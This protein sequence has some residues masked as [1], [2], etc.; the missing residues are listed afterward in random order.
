MC[1]SLPSQGELRLTNV[2]DGCEHTFLLRGVAEKPLAQDHIVL[3]AQAK[4][5]WRHTCVNFAR[6]IQLGGLFAALHTTCNLLLHVLNTQLPP[7]TLTACSLTH[8]LHVC[9]LAYHVQS[10]TT[11]TEYPTST[12]HSHCMQPDSHTA[13]SPPCIPHVIYYYMY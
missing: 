11:C 6:F 9:R 7:C 10:I 3:H 1:I 12:V 13:R 5:R 8:I 2:N 4:T